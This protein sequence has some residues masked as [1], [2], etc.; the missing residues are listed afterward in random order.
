MTSQG[1]GDKNKDTKLCS[2]SFVVNA[3]L[4]FNPFPHEKKMYPTKSKAFVD[5]KLKITKMIISV[6][7]SVENM[8]EKEKKCLYKQFLPFPQCFQKASFSDPLKGV[9]EWEWVKEP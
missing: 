4:D 1:N 3:V 9:I 7:E 2:N 5:D 8:W 6:Y